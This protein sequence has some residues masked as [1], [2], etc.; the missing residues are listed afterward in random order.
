MTT[1]NKTTPYSW[2][3]TD[4]AG[5]TSATRHS[6]EL[7]YSAWAPDPEQQGKHPEGW[8]CV[9]IAYTPSEARDAIAKIN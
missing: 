4:G 7:L 2:R 6:G 9:L 5:I 1:W 8:R 3:R